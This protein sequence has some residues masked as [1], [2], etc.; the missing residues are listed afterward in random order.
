MSISVANY[1]EV[2]QDIYNTGNGYEYGVVVLLDGARTV[3]TVFACNAFM[4]KEL[5]FYM[6]KDKYG[7]NAKILDA[8]LT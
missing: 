5:V 1:K 7:V 8:Y 6:V 3:Y 4:A 2:E